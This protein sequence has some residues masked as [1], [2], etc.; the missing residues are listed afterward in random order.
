MFVHLTLVPYIPSAGE[1]KTKP[2]QHSVKELLNVGIQPQMLLCRCDRPIPENERRKIASFCNVRPSAVVPALDADTIYAVPIAYH[3]QGMD[4]EVLRHFGLPFERCARP[5]ALAEDRERGARAGRRSAHRDRR[6]IHQPSGQLQEPCGGAGAWRHRQPCARAAGMGRQPD[7]RDSRIPCSRL[8][9]VHGIL[10]P[11][12]FG[13]RGIGRQDC[14][15][16][17]C[18]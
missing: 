3:E 12:G 15:G 4:R 11:G 10:V 7:F 6:Q 13:E 9:D 5:H 1:L 18:T 8:E 16:A 14:R 17:L 2:T